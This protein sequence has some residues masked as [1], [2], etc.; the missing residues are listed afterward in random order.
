VQQTNHPELCWE[1]ESPNLR[2]EELACDDTC[3]NIFFFLYF[4]GYTLLY[5]SPNVNRG[6]CISFLLIAFDVKLTTLYLRF[7]V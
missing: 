4:I 3:M 6:D 5:L 7:C 1:S 2:A